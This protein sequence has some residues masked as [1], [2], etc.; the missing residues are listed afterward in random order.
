MAWFFNSLL[1]I[2]IGTYLYSDDVRLLLGGW[3]LVEKAKSEA[4][5]VNSGGLG[6]AL[7]TEE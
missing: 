6:D 2:F 3:E 5:A 7:G 1:F 4:V